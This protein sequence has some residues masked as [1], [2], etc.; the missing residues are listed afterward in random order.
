MAT[1]VDRNAPDASKPRGYRWCIERWNTIVP[2]AAARHVDAYASEPAFEDPIILEV[3]EE[4]CEKAAAKLEDLKDAGEPS[5]WLT[6]DWVIRE[7]NGRPNWRKVLVHQ[8]RQKPRAPTFK[9][10]KMIL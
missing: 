8:R 7:K 4:V 3:W 10:G 9:D 6:L 5:W 2:S 1:D